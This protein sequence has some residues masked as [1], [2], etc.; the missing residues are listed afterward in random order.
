MN[1]RQKFILSAYAAIVTAMVV[2]PPFAVTYR[3]ADI[4]TG[5]HLIWTGSSKSATTNGPLGTVDP[6]KLSA[7]PVGATLVAGALL[8]ATKD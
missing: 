6:A 3:G 7:Q 5:Y 1:K 2:F 4:G 8:L